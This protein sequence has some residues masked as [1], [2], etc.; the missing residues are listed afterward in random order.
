M[1]N[2][3]PILLKKIR[4][5]RL[6]LYLFCDDMFRFSGP[7]TRGNGAGGSGRIGAERR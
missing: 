5:N 7:K 2:H 4:G 6:S 1:S 3:N